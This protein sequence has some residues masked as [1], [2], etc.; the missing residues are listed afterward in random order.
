MPGLRIDLP[1]ATWFVHEVTATYGGDDSARV[2]H[3]DN[4]GGTLICRPDEPV[5]R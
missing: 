4:Y 2:L 3:A 1:Q 5:G